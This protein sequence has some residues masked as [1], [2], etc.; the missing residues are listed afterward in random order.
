M[1]SEVNNTNILQ[2]KELVVSAFSNQT[3]FSNL[4]ITTQ[5]HTADGSYV[6]V[7]QMLYN[8]QLIELKLKLKK[9]DN[10]FFVTS[11]SR[12]REMIGVVDAKY[13]AIYRNDKGNLIK[14][15]QL[16]HTRFEFRE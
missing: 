2:Q 12:Q 15:Y 11:I 5:A 7:Y 9:E 16:N 8:T 1:R 13:I 4:Y 10:V 3:T 14:L 6:K